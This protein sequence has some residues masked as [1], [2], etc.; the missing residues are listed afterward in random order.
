MGRTN[1][2][3]RA[4]TLARF[5]RCPF[6]QGQVR[7]R[8][9]RI[10]PCAL[11]GPPLPRGTRSAS[12]APRGLGGESTVQ[13]RAGT[14]GQS[15]CVSGT[16]SARTAKRA[17]A[18]R[19]VAER[20]KGKKGVCAVRGQT[21]T[22]KADQEEARKGSN[23]RRSPPPR[24]QTNAKRTRRHDTAA[25]DSEQHTTTAGNTRRHRGG[26]GECNCAVVRD[27][28]WKLL[29]ALLTTTVP[30]SSAEQRQ[31]FNSAPRTS[32]HA[33]HQQAATC[34]AVCR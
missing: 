26:G 32:P 24:A 14:V 13:G 33:C 18:A 16:Y 5:D 2:R 19:M 20:G 6:A 30:L 34:R 4:C 11:I 12:A 25:A 17:R 8:M 29:C 21:R 9:H 22:T 27:H 28:P 1:E 7:E 10:P 31:A 3:R 15:V 23:P